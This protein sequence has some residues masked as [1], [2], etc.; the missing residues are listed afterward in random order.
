MEGSI[1]TKQRRMHNN[2]FSQMI[3]LTSRFPPGTTMFVNS[4]LP[5]TSQRGNFNYYSL[6][7]LILAKYRRIRRL[8]LS[9]V[10]LNRNLTALAS[11]VIITLDTSS[12]SNIKGAP[13]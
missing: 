10:M 2:I 5:Q 9:E 13:L 1:Y 4:T 7:L 11:A 8:V 12:S 3:Q 6:I